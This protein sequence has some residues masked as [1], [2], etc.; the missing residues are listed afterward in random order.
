MPRTDRLLAVMRILRSGDPHTA[1]QIAAALKVSVRTIYRDMDTLQSAGVPVEGTR[2]TGYRTTG[3]TTLPP[4]TL[5]AAEL[6]ALN[7][8]IAIVAQAGDPELARAAESLGGKLDAATPQ[9]VIAETDAWKFALHPL[10]DP[11]RGA[12]HLGT[13]RGAIKARQKLVL[14]DLAPDGQPRRHVVRPLRIEAVGRVWILTAWCE[15][16]HDFR[17]FRVDLITRAEALPELFG[18]EPGTRL[19][20]Y[21]ARGP[22]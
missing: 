12:G 9:Q 14:H 11:A 4:L 10:A 17:E 20:D 13:L 19:G 6:D 3:A 18:D 5:T 22:R 7:L 15:S 2:G 1:A 8:G 21:E 16:S